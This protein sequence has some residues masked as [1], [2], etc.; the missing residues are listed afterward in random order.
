LNGN[1]WVLTV[2]DVQENEMIFYDSLA[3]RDLTMKK[4]AFHGGNVQHV[5][6]I[7]C[8]VG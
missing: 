7:I 2:L 3:P 6:G 4:M 5:S 8:P 1:H